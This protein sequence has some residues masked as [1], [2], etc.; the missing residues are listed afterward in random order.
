[1]IIIITE[2]KNIKVHFQQQQPEATT[3]RAMSSFLFTH[4]KYLSKTK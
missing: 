2:K 3:R 4:F 1:M